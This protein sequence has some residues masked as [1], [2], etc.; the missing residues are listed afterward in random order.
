MCQN[1]SYFKEVDNCCNHPLLGSV[2]VFLKC[3]GIQGMCWGMDQWASVLA[4]THYSPHHTLNYKVLSSL[5]KMLLN[6]SFCFPNEKKW[7]AKFQDQNLSQ[8]HSLKTR[9]TANFLASGLETCPLV[10]FLSKHWKLHFNKKTLQHPRDTLHNMA[11]KMVAY[12]L[13]WHHIFH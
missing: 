12:P 3:S 9:W 11:C 10:P 6:I 1:L 5:S 13:K 8:L 2:L 4:L 7:D